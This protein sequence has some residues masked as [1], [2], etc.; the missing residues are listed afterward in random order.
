VRQL[1]FWIEN[2]MVPK[3]ST[4]V[5]PEPL[6]GAPT[7]ARRLAILEAGFDCFCRYG[8]RRT[9]MEDIARAAGLSRAALYLHFANKTDI[10][11]SLIR[12]YFAV[13]ETRVRDALHPG[14]EPVAA[15]SAVFAAKA[16]PEL[17]AMYGSPHGEELLDLNAATSADI[18]QQG[19]D[20]IAT[21]L[22]E[23]LAGEAVQ[24]RVALPDEAGAVAR[25]VIAALKGLKDPGA[26]IEGYRR[27]AARL[28]AILGRG[29]TP[30][31]R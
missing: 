26:G 24:G 14:M 5:L 15:L 16:G 17:A 6:P 10:Y 12:H 8:Y 23:W 4:T 9:A 20:R 2:V 1:T 28:A 13:T 25:T 27:G 30:T 7:D 21:V 31:P 11:R 3:M 29:L 18:V 19:E 22:A